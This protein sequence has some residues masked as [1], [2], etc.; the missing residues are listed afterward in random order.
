[1]LW[2]MPINTQLK[3]ISQASYFGFKLTGSPISKVGTT[4]KMRILQDSHLYHSLREGLTS[5]SLEE[6][7]PIC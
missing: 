4:A 6:L 2:L 1:M 7:L 3:R 5:C